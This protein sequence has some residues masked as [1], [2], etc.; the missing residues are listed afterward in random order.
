MELVHNYQISLDE[1]CNE[2]IDYFI[3]ATDHQKRSTFLAE[4]MGHL[5]AKKILLPAGE[6]CEETKKNKQIFDGMGFLSF[7]TLKDERKEVENLLNRILETNRAGTLNILIDYSCMTKT[8]YAAIIEYLLKNDPDNERI[9]MFFSYTP[10]TI[11]AL[12][13]KSKIRSVDP[14][15]SLNQKNTEKMK[16]LVIGLNSNGELAKELIK[17]LQPSK[18]VLFVPKMPHDPNYHEAVIEYNQELIKKTPTENVYIYPAQYPDQINSMLVSACLDLRLHYNVI[19]VPQG[20]K[21]FALASI[22]LSTRYPDVKLMEI[23]AIEK[24]PDHQG[25]PAGDPV[26]V[27]SVFCPEEDSDDL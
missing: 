9:N 11:N 22:L 18:T 26:I 23:N 1:L 13:V 17:S 27:K 16:A 6:M 15:F 25:L 24:K 3:A 2:R 12:P 5:H 14:L 20:P 8:F 21:T 7:Q 4:N 19:L 10:K